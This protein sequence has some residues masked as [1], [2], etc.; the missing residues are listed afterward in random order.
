[1]DF[2]EKKILKIFDNPEHLLGKCSILN[3]GRNFAPSRF[4]TFAD[5]DPPLFYFVP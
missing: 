5:R 1:M 2:R 3:T 4:S